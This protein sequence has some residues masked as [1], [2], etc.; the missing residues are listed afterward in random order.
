MLARQLRDRGLFSIHGDLVLDKTF[1]DTFSFDPAKFDGEPLKAHNVGPDALLMNFKTV[2]FFFAPAL[3][4]RAVTIS[5]DV[6]PSQLEIVNRMRLT[7][8]PCGDWREHIALDVQTP[9]PT[10]VKVTFSGRYPRSCGE[11]AWSLSL[12]DHARF[13][14]GVFASI[15]KEAGGVWTGAV[16]LGPTPPDARL[17]A[18]L[19][20]APLAEAVRDINKYSNN[21]M[22]RQLFLT[23][24]AEAI[25]GYGAIPPAMTTPA[26]AVTSASP[27]SPAPPEFASTP[28]DNAAESAAPQSPAAAPSPAPAARGSAERSAQLVRDW[29]RRK[30]IAANEL[31]MENGSGLSR[32]ERI[33]AQTLASMLD[34]AWRSSVMP[35]LVSSLSLFG[36]DGTFRKRSRGEPIVG[37]AHVKSGTLNDVRAMAGY[38][39]DANGKRWIVVM[40]INH[41]AALQAQ[42]AQD[43]LLQWVYGG[44]K[45][46]A[47]LSPAG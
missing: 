37:Q 13:D 24:S 34:A 31:V 42:A 21:V 46:P 40:F 12:L 18:T 14:G 2:R 11:S 1:F 6:R 26:A 33:S 5:P 32:K 41:P 23:L 15:W 28:N 45:K 30:G 44:E 36:V 4:D 38:V 17:V 7:E 39:Q 16:R 20:S 3:D 9:T 43:A 25:N 8:G 29:L 47:V 35:E 27:I 19:D 22:A 10:Q